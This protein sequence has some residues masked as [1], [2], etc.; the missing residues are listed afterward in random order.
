VGTGRWAWS[1]RTDPRGT[2]RDRGKS[3]PWSSDADARGGGRISPSG[4]L[5]LVLPQCWAICAPDEGFDA[6][7]QP[8]FEVGRALGRSRRVVRDSAARAARYATVEARRARYGLGVRGDP[9][10]PLT[11]RRGKVEYSCGCT[12]GSAAALRQSAERAIKEGPS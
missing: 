5:T 3:R 7:G 8:Q 10:Q 9:G 1:L 6:A 11:G 12:P 2:V 4:S